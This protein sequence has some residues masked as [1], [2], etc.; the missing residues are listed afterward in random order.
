MGQLA[1]QIEATTTTL[2]PSSPVATAEQLL[3]GPGL[4]Q[5]MGTVAAAIRVLENIAAGAAFH[6]ETRAPLP[7]DGSE[8]DAWLN[9]S[10]GDLFKLVA[11]QWESRGNL[12]STVPGPRGKEGPAGADSTVAGPRGYSNYDL[13][14]QAGFVGT[15]EQYLASLQ[16]RNGT[17]GDNGDNGKDGS[18]I[19]DKNFAPSPA[20]NLLVENY[21]PQPNDQWFHTIG[22]KAYDR[23][24]HLDGEWRLVFRKAE[25]AVLPPQPTNAAPG[26]TFNAPASGATVT[27]GTPITLTATAT[28][29]VAV[30]AVEF[31]N[32]NTGAS[33]GMGNKN[34]T[35][36][37]LPYTPQTAGSLALVARA[38]DNGTPALTSQA[39]V[40][41]TVQA[42]V[43]V[44]VENT[45]P[46]APT[47]AFDPVS[48]M[49]SA[50]HGT[51]SSD[52]LEQRQN[53]G[54]YAPY[55]AVLV[56]NAAH[57]AAEWQVR[58][59]AAAGRNVSNPADS[60]AIAAKV[61]AD[62]E[63]DPESGTVL[64][65]TAQLSQNG[66]NYSDAAGPLRSSYAVMRRKV[67]GANTIKVRQRV[68]VNDGGLSGLEYYLDGVYA[69]W[70][71]QPAL[72]SGEVTINLPDTNEHILAIV[73]AA[74]SRP[75]D[76]GQLLSYA[77]IEALITQGAGTTT[78]IRP[79]KTQNLAYV[80]GDSISVGAGATDAT[81]AWLI[82]L[83]RLLGY[84]VISDGWGYRSLSRSLSTAP[85]RAQVLANF[86]AAAA[87]RTGKLSFIID[88]G[89]ND[90]AFSAAASEQAAA[91]AQ[92]MLQ[93]VRA[94][95]PAVECWI[96]TP[97]T[98]V[99]TGPNGQ[100]EPFRLYQTSLLALK[101]S[102]PWLKL[103]DATDWLGLADLTAD[104]V[105]P[106]N[107]GHALIANRYFSALSGA[108]YVEPVGDIPF[109]INTGEFT[110]NEATY[111]LVR[112]S[113]DFDVN[114][115]ATWMA[116]FKLSDPRSYQQ[117]FAKAFTDG[118]T[119]K[120]FAMYTENGKVISYDYP[121]TD[122]AAGVWC[123]V[124]MSYGQNT[125]AMYGRINGGPIQKVESA[126]MGGFDAQTQDGFTIGANRRINPVGLATPASGIIEN[127]A[128]WNIE[129]D[130]A[131]CR[132]L[133]QS[134]LVH[135]PSQYN[136]PNCLIYGPL[137]RFAAGSAT[138]PN[139][140]DPARPFDIINL[141]A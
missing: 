41:I 43:V 6:L 39:T 5:I 36:Y 11:G 62:P 44:P 61:V 72:G 13:W 121:G 93:L 34:G 125:A 29:D 115:S 12:K 18:R 136:S 76:Q 119:G 14:L 50:A 91:Y 58:V 1:D 71:P 140:A 117:I 109:E 111:A 131:T 75:N 63:P 40:T 27:A 74:N 26:I 35:T 130:D 86:Q 83:R 45:T 57:P 138:M 79:V 32:G 89:T 33:L 70:L 28:D 87:G 123:E 103:M 25:S 105:H 56:D 90:Y 100:G 94:W 21:V 47:Y 126:G 10:T 19:F 128:F 81:R 129:L 23:Y 53:G 38:T 15:R 69:G 60:P 133:I 49:L 64:I 120:G 52:T 99:A 16:G 108:A 4:I 8:G 104:G 98:R 110:V 95:N 92:Q 127:V 135:N 37:T 48:R 17:D 88:L 85:E 97:V 114:T 84:D 22:L 30:S 118:S 82:R 54:A 122:F 141:S 9:G 46:A 113:K 101:D 24:A 116:R 137:K 65:T 96:K 31:L 80:V 73:E 59:K 78:L 124:L 134:N 77:T 42:V 67:A 112:D 7:A 66:I 132:A 102:L 2:V 107:G 51:L 106:N 55:A 68:D 139:L 3:T 20:H